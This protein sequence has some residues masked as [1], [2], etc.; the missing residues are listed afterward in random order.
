MDLAWIDSDTNGC[1]KLGSRESDLPPTSR[2]SS[3]N[4]LIWLLRLILLLLSSPFQAIV[5]L[6]TQIPNVAFVA[7]IQRW[8]GVLKDEGDDFCGLMI[9]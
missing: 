2:Y 8:T 3:Q 7:E 9:Y 5:G 4:E 6:R 1:P